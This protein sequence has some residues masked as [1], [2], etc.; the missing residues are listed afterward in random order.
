MRNSNVL[1]VPVNEEKAETV[2]LVQLAFV[3]SVFDRG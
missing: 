1:V 3:D 2:K